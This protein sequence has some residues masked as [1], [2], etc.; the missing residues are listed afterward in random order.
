MLKALESQ[1]KLK[2]KTRLIIDTSGSMQATISERSVVTAQEAG[3][4]LGSMIREL[5]EEVRAFS[6]ATTTIEVPARRG[7][8]FVDSFKSGQ[9]GHSTDFHQAYKFAE[10][11]APGFDR[12]IFVSDMQS[13]TAV[14]PPDSIGYMFNVAA[15]E[16]AVGYGPS[17][18]SIDGFSA[19]A[20]KWMVEYERGL[21]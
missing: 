12:T 7:F 4:V 21:S 19:S 11:A 18:T 1:P 8:A 10:R 16:N 20:L 5:G 14:Q 9:V 2:G 13:W 15:Y 6:F 3:A 17:W